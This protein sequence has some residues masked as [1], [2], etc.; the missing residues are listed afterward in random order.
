MPLAHRVSP[1]TMYVVVEQPIGVKEEDIKK[2][3]AVERAQENGVEKH[4]RMSN[5]TYVCDGEWWRRTININALKQLHPISSPVA[6]KL[7]PLSGNFGRP[8]CGSM[9]WLLLACCGLIS[10]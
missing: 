10:I 1:I 4:Q 7:L 3:K 9:A 6:G 8:K 5:R 2:G